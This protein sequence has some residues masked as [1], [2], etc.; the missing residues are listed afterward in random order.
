MDQQEDNYNCA[1]DPT[2]AQ[3]LTRQS[4]NSWRVT[5]TA[6]FLLATGGC[7]EFA[8][9]AGGELVEEEPSWDAGK[10]E[11]GSLDASV[12]SGPS[13]ARATASS[14]VTSP[15]TDREPTDRKVLTLD[16]GTL[17]ASGLDANSATGTGEAVLSGG[18]ADAAL[19]HSGHGSSQSPAGSHTRHERD[20]GCVP[21]CEI[22]YECGNSVTEPGEECDEGLTGSASCNGPA[23]GAVGCHYAR[24]GDGHTSADEDCDV[25]TD[26]PTCNG[27]DAGPNAC[28]RPSCGDAYHNAEAEECDPG[29]ETQECNGPAAGSN[30]CQMRRCGDG[31]VNEVAG[32]ECELAEEL[33]CNGPAA[34]AAACRIGSCGDGY[35]SQSDSTAACFDDCL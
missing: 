31:Y 6:S 13:S 9:F 1:S 34:G 8:G 26:S 21:T 28:K 4:V 33:G 3:P 15:G 29:F 11:S 35:C 16:A 2:R 7:A 5:V 25:Q 32:E 19:S 12:E 23:A 17:D 14:Q 10:F 27:P 18:F 22:E 24:C 20:A 30:G